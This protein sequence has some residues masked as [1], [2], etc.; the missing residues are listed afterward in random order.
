MTSTITPSN[1]ADAQKRGVITQEK[2]LD[3]E[4]V[5]R[6]IQEAIL[7]RA[8][9]QF[10]HTPGYAELKEKIHNYM[11]LFCACLNAQD[12]QQ[13]TAK[14]QNYNQFATGLRAAFYELKAALQ[15][16]A[17][18]ENVLAFGPTITLEFNIE[19]KQKETLQ[20]ICA[21]TQITKQGS[22]PPDMQKYIPSQ[23]RILSPI[24]LRKKFLTPF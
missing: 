22:F 24:T 14:K 6:S 19:D 15:A 16:Q 5:Q 2:R 9:E 8:D 21:N 10:S 12:D 7:T 17:H 23:K 11:E 3:I 4:K 18:G 1:L 13:T 20:E